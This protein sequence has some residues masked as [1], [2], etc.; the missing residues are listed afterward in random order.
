MTA[1]AFSWVVTVASLVGTVLNVKK[2][3]LCF[4]I[5]SVSNLAWLCYDVWLGLYSR[6]MLDSVHFAFAL[7]GIVSWRKK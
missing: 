1:L 4:W 5:W 7:W 6:A 2:N 3:P